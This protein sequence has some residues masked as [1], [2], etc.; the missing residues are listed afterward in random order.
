MT[1]QDARYQASMPMPSEISATPE[2]NQILVTD[3]LPRNSK[4]RQRVM[5]SSAVSQHD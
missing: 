3:C 1:I 4:S 5:S 2:V